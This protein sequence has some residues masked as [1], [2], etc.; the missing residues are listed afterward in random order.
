MNINKVL[1]I[2]IFIAGIFLGSAGFYFFQNQKNLS[3]D[4]A[5][6]I[7][8]DFINKAVQ[9]QDPNITASILDTTEE[10][11]VYK[12]HLKIE[13]NEYDS[14]ITKDGKYLF[15]TAFNLEDEKAKEEAEKQA[16]Q[17]SNASPDA[18]LASLAQC[19]TEKGAKFYGAFWCSHCKNQKEMFGES[20]ALLPYVECSTPDG[21][22][23]LDIC[24]NNQIESYPTWEF[25]DGSRESGEV[26]L[27]KL[28]EKTGCQLPQ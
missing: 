9:E 6:K 4:E 5:S 15:S 8:I 24:K 19:L 23:Q 11:G 3:M 2:A 13:G 25:S 10:N 18:T 1:F 21:N 20:A 12:L 16:E 27:E 17:E 14:F 26:S 28:S 22:G 7:A